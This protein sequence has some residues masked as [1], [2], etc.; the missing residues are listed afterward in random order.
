MLFRSQLELEESRAHT[1]SEAAGAALAAV[2]ARVQAARAAQ[3]AAEEALEHARS[4]REAARAELTSLEALQAAALSAHAG[5][6]SE[7]L[8]SSGLA[9]RPRLAA[10]LEVEPG[11][12]RA[13]E[14]ALGDYLEAV[15]V[16]ELDALSPALAT[17]AAGS[18]TLL[19]ARAGA[20]PEIGRAH[21]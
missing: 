14:T 21:V 8:R 15:C 20:S 4:A 6:A 11:W 1:H 9:G 16:E 19:E 2:Q 3:L 17:L 10:T 18:L 12:E 13:V 5:E 7:W